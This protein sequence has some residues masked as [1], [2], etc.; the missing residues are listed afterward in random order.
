MTQN[1]QGLAKDHHNLEAWFAGF[2][3]RTERGQADVALLQETRVTQGGVSALENQHARGWGYTVDRS[4]NPLSFWSPATATRGGF[5][6]LFKPDALLTAPRPVWEEH[7]SPWFMAAEAELSGGPVTIINVYGPSC[8]RKQEREEL[9]AALRGLPRPA[10][11]LLLGGDFNCTLDPELDR[12]HGSRATH[13][14]DELQRLLEHWQLRDASQDDQD[15]V[16][17]EGDKRDYHARCHTYWYQLPNGDLASSR[18]DRW[19]V[20]TAVAG[21]IRELVAEPP[22]NH[23]D[24]DA[25]ALVLVPPCGHPPSRRQHQQRRLRYPLPFGCQEP[26]QQL[27]RTAL[28]RFESTNRDGGAATTASAWDACKVSIRR[29]C[30][31]L[32]RQRLKKQR[33]AFQQRRK[34]LGLA[35]KAALRIADRRSATAPATIHSI[36][37]QLEGLALD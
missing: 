18:L 19:Y 32:I 7:W 34:R 23:S 22:A 1:V 14:S 31:Q 28:E 3:L 33:K 17:R 9:F 21:D 24:H 35:L 27:S 15:C 37:T 26:V 5:A 20:S 16:R 11:R 13:G 30:L 10:G 4:A 6:I 25:V 29:D 2:R 12:S 36:T 8:Q